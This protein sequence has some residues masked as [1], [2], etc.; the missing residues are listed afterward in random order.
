MEARV[1]RYAGMSVQTI[2]FFI[3]TVLAPNDPVGQGQIPTYK[4][5]SARY[6]TVIHIMAKFVDPSF[7][8]YL[9]NIPILTVVTPN[10]LEGKSQIP[11]HTF[12]SKVCP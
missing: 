6:L 1:Q 3:W 7:K 2:I 12:P 4:I 11:S 8:C 9:T 5:L 10:D